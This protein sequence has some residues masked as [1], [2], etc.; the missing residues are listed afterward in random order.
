MFSGIGPHNDKQTKGIEGT[1]ETNAEKQDVE[2][3]RLPMPPSTTN[4]K[5]ISA[6]AL[7][8]ARRKVISNSV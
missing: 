8:A 4:I 7:V 6:A 5:A 2:P 3:T 1:A